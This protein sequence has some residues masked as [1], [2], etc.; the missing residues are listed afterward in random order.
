MAKGS[1]DNYIPT[2]QFRNMRACMVCSIVKTQ[3]QFMKD[4]CPNCSFLELRG[5]ADQVADCTSQV[6]EG[7]ITVSDARGSWVARWQRLD[8]KYVRG[9]YAVQVEGI[10]PDD[11]ISS[12]EE[13][14][15]HYI[16]RDG[17]VNEALPTDA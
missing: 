9:V 6:F 10:L 8:G 7:L 16:P 15:I 12:V 13:Q 5:N 3:A 17:S 1:E 2:G 4:G 11:V 14:G